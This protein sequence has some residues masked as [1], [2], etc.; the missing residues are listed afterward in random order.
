MENVQAEENKITELLTF[1][2]GTEFKQ[3]H[4]QN[5]F[6]L[7]FKCSDKLMTFGDEIG[8]NFNIHGDSGSERI[9]Q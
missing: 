4:E 2:K 3:N 9:D 8:I 6:V 7:F 1:K 5:N